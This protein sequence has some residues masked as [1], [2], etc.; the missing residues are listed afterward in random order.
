[1]GGS[2][3]YFFLLVEIQTANLGAAYDARCPTGQDMIRVV[4]AP[5]SPEV[6]SVLVA[7]GLCSAEKVFDGEDRA[8]PSS[9]AGAICVFP[10]CPEIADIS[11]HS[12]VLISI[13]EWEGYPTD[14]S[15]HGSHSFLQSF[16]LSGQ[17]TLSASA[18]SQVPH[19][20]WLACYCG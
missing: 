16:I 11:L 18:T 8:L 7:I 13:H 2:Y 5:V 1:M 12:T 9:G 3:L 15:I 14:P 6:R 19:P 17:R 10:T 20:L 4:W